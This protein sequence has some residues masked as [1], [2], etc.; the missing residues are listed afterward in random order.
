M[1]LKR[2]FYASHTVGYAKSGAAQSDDGNFNR[3]SQQTSNLF[4]IRILRVTQDTSYRELTADEI[5]Q[6][7]QQGCSAEGDTWRLIQVG[8]GFQAGLVQYT[9]FAGA[10]QIGA[11]GGYTS[12]TCKKPSLIRHATIRDC[13]LSD[14]V[15]I[16]KVGVQIS[17][18]E[19]GAG[20]VI[21]NV[22]LLETRNDARFGNGIEIEVLNEG[23]G[24][25]VI[26]FSEL[27]AQFAHLLCLHRYRP[28]LI[29]RLER[30]ARAAAERA[31]ASRG[32]VGTGAHI[33][34]A[35]EIIDVHV[36]SAAKINAAMSLRNGTILSTM[37]APTSVGPGVQAEDFIFAEGA[38]VDGAAMLSETYVGQATR[39][40][41][42]FAAESSLFFANCEAFHGEACSVFAG[43]YTV[44][45]HKGSLLIAGL[46][47][48]YNAGSGTNQSNHMYKLGPVH[49]GRL[50]RGSKTGSFSYM[51][52]PCRVGPFSVVLGK[53][54][55]SFDTGCFPFSHIEAL[56]D[57]R[58]SL[59]PGF[60]LTTVGTMRD[61][62]KWPTRDRR[63]QNKRDHI[64]FDVFSP[65]TVGRML[66][67]IDVLHEFQKKTDRSVPSVTIQ[68]ADIKR[69]F[70]RTGQKLF[71]RGVFMY[72]AEKIVRRIE[73]ALEAGTFSS[74]DT[75]RAD[76]GSEHSKEWVDVGGQL[77]PTG[78]LQTL[79]ADI[80]EGRIADVEAFRDRLE[81]VHKCYEKDE[82]VWVKETYRQLT[83][84]ELEQA[85]SEQLTEVVETLR[86]HRKEFLDAVLVDA[87]KE[88]DELSAV[89]FGTDGSA[90]APLDD[91]RAVR[92]DY[93][94]NKFVQQLRDEIASLEQRVESLKERLSF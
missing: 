89:G 91:F 17:G 5:T 46:F 60:N 12:G 69:V 68:G 8:E 34:S 44:T 51:M 47:S 90:E 53:H 93:D 52:W 61:G 80:E 87:V 24:R 58:C 88:F 92:G 82:W 54:T 41:R 76:P 21:E 33:C 70:L 40:G 26:L 25:D 14:N 10:V 42:Q 13:S 55:R 30:M 39:V 22:G 63:E 1:V 48:F 71:R 37:E 62:A 29:E 78:R 31:W 19:I 56:P 79:V 45:H 36:G 23:G 84:V 50:E 74:S 75:F 77:M 66:A 57:G 43:P 32:T 64:D 85:E 16:D 49:E 81:E 4:R 2:Y 3:R 59:I 38:K 18:Y 20:V 83:G 72:L 67:G 15:R 11:L 7:K 86:I 9:H 35:T 94:S 27:S 65:Y 73:T 6:L 28:R